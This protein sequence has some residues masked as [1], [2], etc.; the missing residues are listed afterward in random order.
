MLFFCLK[1]NQIFSQIEIDTAQIFFNAKMRLFPIWFYQTS[2]TELYSKEYLEGYMSFKPEINNVVTEGFDNDFFFFELNA[3]LYVDSNNIKEIEKNIFF[4]PTYFDPPFEGK[5]IIFCYVKKWN[6][7]FLLNGTENTDFTYFYY[8]LK[9]SSYMIDLGDKYYKYKIEG[10]DLETIC[11][12]AKK[13]KN[14]AW[15][16]GSVLR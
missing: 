16:R 9:K 3:K 13:S 8:S 1:N 5:K 7:L 10:I 4:T 6:E 12:K 15:I 14:K 2:S 11:K